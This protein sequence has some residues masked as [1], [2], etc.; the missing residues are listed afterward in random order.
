VDLTFL[1]RV[2][3]DAETNLTVL[4]EAQLDAR[5]SEAHDALI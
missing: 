1:D 4:T 2:I 3:G 5:I